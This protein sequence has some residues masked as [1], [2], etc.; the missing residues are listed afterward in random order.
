[1]L[2]T[3]FDLSQHEAD[4]EIRSVHVDAGDQRDEAEGIFTASDDAEDAGISLDADAPSDVYVDDDADLDVTVSNDGD[5][6]ATTN[7]T[8]MID[9]EEVNSDDLDLEAGDSISESYDF[10]TAAEGDTD[11]SV[12]TDDA[13]ASGTLS[14]SAGDANGDDANGADDD[15]SDDD[16]GVDDDESTPGFGVAVAIVALLA[17]AM[18]AIRRDN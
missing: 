18:L 13:D 10:D 2:T 3:S 8:V 14:V 5:E 9:G 15:H 12:E 11:W 16:T 4:E 1:M 7:Y 17:A 6:N